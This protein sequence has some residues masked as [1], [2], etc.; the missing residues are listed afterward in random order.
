MDLK[1]LL[2]LSL[3]GRLNSEVNFFIRELFEVFYFPSDFIDP[4]CCLHCWRMCNDWQAEASNSRQIKIL[5]SSVWFVL[6]SCQTF[7]VPL[8][9]LI[10]EYL[11]LRHVFIEYLVVIRRK[12][13]S[14]DWNG[15]MLFTET[16][17]MKKKWEM[18]DCAVLILYQ[19]RDFQLVT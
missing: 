19:V 4:L 6:K 8:S 11:D 3:L 9:V 12:K 18:H 15:L 13:N 2:C 5:F 16:N 17:G 10:E 1:G 7:A 14:V